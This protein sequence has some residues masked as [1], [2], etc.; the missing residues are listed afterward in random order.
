MLLITSKT[1][2]ME[3]VSSVSFFTNS[4]NDKMFSANFLVLDT[5]LAKA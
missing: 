5:S 1:E 2:L 4:L 3:C